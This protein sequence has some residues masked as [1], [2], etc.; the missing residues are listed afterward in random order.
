MPIELFG[1]LDSI[2]Q[3]T[4]TPTNDLIAFIVAGQSNSDGRVPLANGPSWLNQSN[5][6]VTGVKMYNI[7]IS[8]HQ[9]DNF[10]LGTN[11]GADVW[12]QTTWA[13][14]MIAMHNYYIGKNQNVYMIKRTKGGTSINIQS[15]DTKGCWN[16]DFTGITTQTSG[17]V[18]LE[19]L[20]W[21]Y[22][23]AVT[24]ATSIGKTLNVKGIL[25]HQ[26][27]GDYLPQY[28]ADNYYQNFKD[29]IYYIRNTIVG[30]SILP[31]VY[32][33][34]S[35]TSAQ[36]NATVEAAQF[37]IALEDVNAHCVN[38]AAGT[39]LDAYHF[40]ATSSIYFG[41]QVYNIIKNF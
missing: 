23:S 21:Y 37:Q 25:W 30:N 35:H 2:G 4:V 24:Y 38:M 5:P 32:G 15:G 1:F 3:Q 20:Y 17:N 28:A 27:E 14:D 40:D 36:Y 13:F 31:I 41:D 39:L 18:L 6:T 19:E 33:S 22:Q 34:I 10:K 9:F 12:T 26:G 8:P 11:S 16:V 7:N 29:V